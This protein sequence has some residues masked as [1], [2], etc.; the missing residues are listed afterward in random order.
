M[1]AE[2]STGSEQSVSDKVLCV[3]RECFLDPNAPHRQSLKVKKKKKR[4]FISEG[5]QLV[6]EKKG[7]NKKPLQKGQK[8]GIL[9]LKKGFKN[10]TLAQAS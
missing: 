3:R 6:R 5:R 8:K 4:S 2:G 10:K 7:P 9:F 1:A